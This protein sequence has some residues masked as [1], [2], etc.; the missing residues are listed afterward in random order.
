MLFLDVAKIVE[1]QRTC[2]RFHRVEVGDG[3]TVFFWFDNLSKIETIFNL[4][5]PQGSMTWEFIEMKQCK[6]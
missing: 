3:S 6:W 5:G 1:A 2:K 4:T